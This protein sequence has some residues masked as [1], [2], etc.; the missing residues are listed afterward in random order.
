M[1]TLQLGLK[2]F[3][4][5]Q[6]TGIHEDVWEPFE[7]SLAVINGLLKAYDD[8]EDP[9]QVRED[10]LEQSL[11]ILNEAA[12]RAI[13]CD[14]DRIVIALGEGGSKAPGSDRTRTGKASALLRSDR[15]LP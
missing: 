15:G 8:V 2:A 3:S 10:D 1:G 5:L 12:N 6:I 11:E 14:L 13:E 9:Q 7:S 4:G